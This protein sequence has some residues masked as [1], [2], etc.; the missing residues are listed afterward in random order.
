MEKFKRIVEKW[1]KIQTHIAFLNIQKKIGAKNLLRI[2]TEN[3]G[4]MIK[5]VRAFTRKNEIK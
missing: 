4:Q 1:I 3:L 5:K 2:K